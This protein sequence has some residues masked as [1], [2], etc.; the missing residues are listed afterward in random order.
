MSFYLFRFYYINYLF[1]TANFTSIILF[2]EAKASED[3]CTRFVLKNHIS[4]TY[5]YIR[6]EN[7]FTGCRVYPVGFVKCFDIE[8][9]CFILNQ[10]GQL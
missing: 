4:A 3:V 5:P 6:S 1:I 7:N 10:S 9:F 2:L 8:V